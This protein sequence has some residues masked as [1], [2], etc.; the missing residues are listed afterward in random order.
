MKLQVQTALAALVLGMCSTITFAD[1]ADRGGGNDFDPPM[2]S[3]PSKC[4]DCHESFKVKVHV[5]EKCEIKIKHP[6]LFLKEGTT[7]NNYFD[8]KTNAKYTLKVWSDNPAMGQNK[9]KAIGPGGHVGLTYETTSGMGPGSQNIILGVPKHNLAKGETHYK[10][11]V[12]ADGAGWQD[13]GWYE[14]KYN[15]QVSF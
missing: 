4:D 13:A 6:T 14:D 7:A 9:A 1:E 8:V 2:Y 15:V 3:A 10:V 5:P 11:K 12:T